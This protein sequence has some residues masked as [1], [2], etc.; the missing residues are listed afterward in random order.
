M[1]DSGALVWCADCSYTPHS[2][3]V[4]YEGKERKKERM[5]EEEEEEEKEQEQEQE[6]EE[7]QQQNW[8]LH[9]KRSFACPCTKPKRCDKM[10]TPS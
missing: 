8:N 7:Q 6:Q 1:S 10:I 4:K 5:K 3:W 2:F 9:I